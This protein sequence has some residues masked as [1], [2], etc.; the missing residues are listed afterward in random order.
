[1]NFYPSLVVFDYF[2]VLMDNK[3]LIWIKGQEMK[4]SSI[5]ISKNLLA[6]LKKLKE[7]DGFT[8]YE[9]LLEEMVHEKIKRTHAIT[10]SDYLPVGTV[11]EIESRVAFIKEIR[12]DKIIFNDGFWVFNESLACKQLVKLADSVEKFEGVVSC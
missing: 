11:V 7:F 10:Y 4:T 12:G 1:M 3:F 2:A 8:T 9:N 6:K 5:K